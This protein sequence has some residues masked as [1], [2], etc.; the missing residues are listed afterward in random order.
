MKR[1]SSRAGGE[2]NAGRVAWLVTRVGVNPEG[3]GRLEK[4]AEPPRTTHGQEGPPMPR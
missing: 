2:G 1:L 4:Q 3:G